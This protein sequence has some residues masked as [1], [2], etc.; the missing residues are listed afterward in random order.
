LPHSVLCLME[1]RQELTAIPL[2]PELHREIG[3]ITL[4]REPHPALLAAM[5]ST[6]QHLDLQ[7][8]MDALLEY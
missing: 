3:L 5:M 2:V 8:R 7:Y 6:V 4:H 1:M